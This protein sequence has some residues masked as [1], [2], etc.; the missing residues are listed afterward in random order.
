MS[1]P[2][3]ILKH[4]HRVIEQVM[5][6]LEGV[7]LRLD[8]GLKVPAE[9]LSEISDFIT[10]FADC[11][12]HKKEET[13]L[14]PALERCGITRQGGPLGVIEREHEIE[15]KLVGEFRIAIAEYKDGDAQA[16]RRFVEAARSFVRMLIGHIET[17]DGILFRIGDEVL[18]DEDK[19][20]LMESF[21]TFEADNRLRPLA[22]YERKASEL[23]NIWA[24]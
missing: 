18:D 22:D 23:E 21:R 14:F 15:R 8:G 13:L 3:H 2:F 24:C 7:C 6:A 11:Y 9:A 19:A 17:E 10:S 4:E 1:K 16:I 12:H 20:E 5:R